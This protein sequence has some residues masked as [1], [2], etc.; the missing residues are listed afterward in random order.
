MFLRKKLFAP[1][2]L[3]L[4]AR[5]AIGMMCLLALV[6][7]ISLY[8]VETSDYTMFVSQWYD[9]IQTHSGFAALKYNFSNY[10]VPYL[11]LL[12]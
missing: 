12:A 3:Q 7:R 8:H 10:N 11:Y 2:V 1:D 4:L 6:L 9:F 5:C